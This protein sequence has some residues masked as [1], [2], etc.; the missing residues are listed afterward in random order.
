MTALNP[1]PAITACATNK[2]LSA[3]G[4]NQVA[5]PD[6]LNEVAATD[7]CAAPGSLVKT[8]SPPPGTM[9]GL[10]DTT[11]TIAVKDQA[12]NQST[13]SAVITVVKFSAGDFV[14]FSQEHTQIHANT[15]V[16]TG[17]VGANASLPDP[18]GGADDKEEVEIGMRVQMLQAG[19]NVVGDTVRLR[20]DAEV[21]NVHFNEQFFSPDASI[22]GA[23]VTPQSLPVLIILPP[24]PIVTPGAMDIA[25]PANQ[26]MT[27]AAGSYRKI[28]VNHD[29]TLILTGGVYHVE[30]LDIRQDA[31]LHFTAPAEVRVKNEMDTDAQAFIGPA[32]AAPSLTASQ[33]IF[34]IEGM[35]DGSELT[36]TAAQIGE[37]NTV[38]AN[39]YAPNGTVRLRANTIATGA[40]IGKRA[41][42]GERVELRSKSA[43]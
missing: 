1:P 34:Y 30:S 8:Q 11:V 9:I 3:N 19:S 25:V 20:S 31:K 29:A 28:T 16:H 12:G 4:A 32:P 14:V 18:N 17:S 22:L 37:R 27:L 33:I 36:S 35:D 40:F 42:I 6:L 10:G 26:M 41:Q 15:K 24:A 2:K 7:N 23:Q 39:F 13:C 38:I 5:V 21:H 43:F